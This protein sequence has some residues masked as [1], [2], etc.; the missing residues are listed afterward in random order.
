MIQEQPEIVME[1]PTFC[2]RQQYERTELKWEWNDEWELLPLSNVDEHYVVDIADADF[3]RDRSVRKEI[4]PHRNGTYR[5]RFTYSEKGRNISRWIL[6][7]YPG[8]PLEA[9]HINRI[10]NDA[11][12]CNLRPVNRVQN[13]V[14]RGKQKGNYTSKF[15]GV[16]GVENTKGVTWRMY[17][18]G[19][20]IAY[21]TEL[22]AAIAWNIERRRLFGH[23]SYQNPIPLGYENYVPEPI[24]LTNKN[25]YHGIEKCGNRYTARIKHKKIKIPLGI[26]DTPEEA[27]RA[28]DKGAIYYQGPNAKYIN[29]PNEVEGRTLLNPTVAE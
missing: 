18:C 11:R 14:N 15:V 5:L 21:K 28:Y 8:N 1:L 20:D 19:K 16:Y 2:P 13:N 7:L 25:G 6:G 24:V 23:Y 22:D 12:K 3:F 27:A 17:C 10:T 29:F 26:Y 9:D 4:N